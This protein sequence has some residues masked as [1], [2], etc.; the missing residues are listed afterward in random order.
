MRYRHIIFAL[1]VGGQ[2]LASCS[3]PA[4]SPVQVPAPDDPAASPSHGNHGAM[5]VIDT[6]RLIPA[7][8]GTADLVLK[9]GEIPA[10]NPE[11]VG[12]FRFDCTFSHMSFDDP[13]VYP[14]QPGAAHLH[15]FFGNT[16]VDA[17]T[18]SQSLATTGNSTCRGGIANRSG[19]WVPSIVDTS[20]GAP[21]AP[22]H[23]QVYYK[24]GYGGVAPNQISVIPA[25]L[26][27][28]AGDAKA[29]GPQSDLNQVSWS[30][31]TSSNGQRAHSI[32]GDCAVGDLVNM[33][34]NFPQCWDGINLDSADHKSHMAQAD[35]GCPASHP[36]A[37]PAITFNVKYRVPAGGVAAWRLASDM[38]AT[39]LPG[40]FSAHADW[41]NGWN[42]EI[43]RTITTNCLQGALECKMD[44]LGDGRMLG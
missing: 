28:I 35:N 3:V 36:V 39:D 11:V 24:S 22:D 1:C 42:E 7:V 30:C 12:T 15:T 21:V 23:L 31:P 41:W 34:I 44:L 29:S 16:G 37:I 5:P 2:S 10:A 25:G 38:Y 43:I 27:M 8:E 19:Y 26:R 32:P 17:F 6:S 20:T 40:G 14:G 18:T 9:Q 13:I 33:M 4:L